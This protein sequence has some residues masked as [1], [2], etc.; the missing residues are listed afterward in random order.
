M[1]QKILLGSYG[2]DLIIDYSR[3]RPSGEPLKTKGGYASGPEILI[4]THDFIRKT[5]KNAQGRKL[6]P[7]EMH[8]MFCYAL[9]S[10]SSGSLRRSAGMC[11]FGFDYSDP[12]RERYNHIFYSLS[13]WFFRET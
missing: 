11:I 5:L 9:E 13:G 4:Q 10:G 3:V 1:G 7:I 6:R 2:S 12:P 8:D